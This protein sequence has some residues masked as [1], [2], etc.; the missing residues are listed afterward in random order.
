MLYG[1][2]AG[3]LVTVVAVSGIIWGSIGLLAN[4]LIETDDANDCVENSNKSRKRNAPSKRY[5]HQFH[6]TDEQ[7]RT[8]E[9]YNWRITTALNS[10]IALGAVIAAVFTIKTF[11]AISSQTQ[12][13][14]QTV[15]EGQKVLS[16][17]NLQ[18]QAAQAQVAVSEEQNRIATRALI[19]S[20]RAWLRLTVS[21]NQ[22]SLSWL[23]NI[24]ELNVN[25]ELQ[26]IG[27]GPALDVILTAE[28][29][30]GGSIVDTRTIQNYCQTMAGEG[31]TLFPGEP[32]LPDHQDIVL[33]PW[34]L[35][36]YLDRYRNNGDLSKNILPL[37]LLVCARYNLPGDPVPHYTGRAFN[38]RDTLGGAGYSYVYQTLPVGS[39]ILPIITFGGV[40]D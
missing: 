18:A 32:Y 9:E 31:P 27:Q 36:H 7:H 14:W 15:R 19:S 39:V 11:S 17:A 4:G 40:T 23:D 29:E 28:L 25:P 21:S 2:I 35:E 12:A 37:N 20:N 16:A 38:V 10:I 3:A 34:I 22:A 13:V 24:A 30:I 33:K 5:R 6:G 1:Q 8:A 26:N